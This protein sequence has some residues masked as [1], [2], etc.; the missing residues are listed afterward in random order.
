[1]KCKF[2]YQKDETQG[3][4]FFECHYTAMI[5]KDFQKE[6]GIKLEMTGIEPCCKSLTKLKQSRKIRGVIYALINA[7]TY[8]IWKA[9]NHFVL[10][11]QTFTPQ[12]IL[13]EARE[14]I[15]QRILHLQQ[16][17]HNYNTSIDFILNR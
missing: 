16:Y 12:Q 1:M 13:Q 15:T 7:V 10:K 9:R 4:L 3:H 2:C 14:Q 6:W 5:W 8:H 17:K 11:I